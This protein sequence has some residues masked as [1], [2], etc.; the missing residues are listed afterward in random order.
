MNVG[1][2]EGL[3]GNKAIGK[4]FLRPGIRSLMA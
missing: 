3:G 2:K 1:K 4:R